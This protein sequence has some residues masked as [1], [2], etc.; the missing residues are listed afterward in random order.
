MYRT[1]MISNILLLCFLSVVGC[2]NEEVPVLTTSSVTDVTAYSAKSGGNIINEGSDP[3]NARGVCWSDVNGPTIN[4]NKTSDGVGTGEFSSTITG[5]TSGQ[6]YFVR[7]YATNSAGTSYG[8]EK[9]FVTLSD[10]VQPGS[11]IIADHKAVDDFNKIPDR[12]I[13]SVKKMYVYFPGMSHSAAYRIG[14]TLLEANNPKYQVNVGVAQ[15]ETD[16]YLRAQDNISGYATEDMW[17]TGYGYPEGTR[18]SWHDTI[19]KLI[20]AYNNAGYP[21]DVIGYG[22]CW[23]MM[24]S[25]VSTTADPVYGVKWH[26]T[27][28]NGPPDNTHG[29]GLDAADFAITG[30][31]VCM[32]TYLN[33]TEYFN[34]YCRTNGIKTKVVFTTGV[35]DAWVYDGEPMYQASIKYKY[36]RD[37]VKADPKRIL[38]DYAD[39]LCYDDGSSIMHTTTADGFTYPSITPT[40]LG[41]GNVGHIGA[42]GAVRIAKAEWW[43]LARIAGWDGK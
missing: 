19:P 27:S 36:I 13:D 3:I 26:G 11:Q 15:S 23:T 21:F 18:P 20:K 43:L 38:F 16:H 4:D 10:V 39:I 22:W 8:D 1:N 32:D 2:K 35:V 17:Y 7:A 28:R 5:L 29:F 9:T 12:W 24:A 31:P 6:S 42:A 33:A 37:F 41:D 25:Y 14:L 34:D 30:N 40:N